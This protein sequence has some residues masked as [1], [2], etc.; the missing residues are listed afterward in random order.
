NACTPGFIA[1]DLT[2]SYASGRGKSPE[3]LGMKSPREGANTPIFLLFGKTA[4]SGHY[5]GSD[6]KRSPLDRYREPGSP[7]YSGD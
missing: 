2:R 3:E 7:P 6:A 4:G 5:F 1:T